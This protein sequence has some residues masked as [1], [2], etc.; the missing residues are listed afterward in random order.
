MGKETG[1]EMCGDTSK[2]VGVVVWRLMCS[3]SAPRAFCNPSEKVKEWYKNSPLFWPF[4]LPA[5]KRVSGSAALNWLAWGCLDA[6]DRQDKRSDHGLREGIGPWASIDNFDL[7]S[8]RSFESAFWTSPFW[9]TWL[10]ILWSSLWGK[11]ELKAQR[12]PSWGG[13]CTHSWGHLWGPS[14]MVW[15]WV[16]EFSGTRISRTFTSCISE[17]DSVLFEFI[18]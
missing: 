8:F 3:S 4:K 6:A 7:L 9:L 15:M 14:W 1:S 16:D 5:T 10:E 2:V 17:S 18:W 13:F 12:L 11:K